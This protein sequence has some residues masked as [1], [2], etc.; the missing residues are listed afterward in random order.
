MG[1]IGDPWSESK[2]PSG[3]GAAGSPPTVDIR[4]PAEER[5]P[6]PEGRARGRGGRGGSRGP[7]FFICAGD[8]GRG[9][10]FFFARMREGRR[11][12]GGGRG[13]VGRYF[14]QNYIFTYNI[15]S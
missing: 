8:A 1:A 15:L 6:S 10:V 14:N 9:G 13:G 11:A 4:R 2:A 5:G 12:G 7:P 3:G